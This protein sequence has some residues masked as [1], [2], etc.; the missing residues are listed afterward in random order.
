MPFQDLKIRISFINLFSV[1]STPRQTEFSDDEDF[2]HTEESTGLKMTF[3]DYADLLKVK[4]TQ[5]LSSVTRH[6][7]EL[8]FRGRH[9]VWDSRSENVR[10]SIVAIILLLCLFPFVLPH[11]QHYASVISQ[12]SRYFCV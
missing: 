8:Y 4:T 11:Y 5:T 9:N 2:P 1:T 12:H 6:T 7:S 10:R 3:R